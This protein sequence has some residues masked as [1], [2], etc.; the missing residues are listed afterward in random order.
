MSLSLQI[1]RH[2]KAEEASA[3]VRDHERALKGRG[4]KAAEQAGL[5]LAWLEEPP[6]LVLCSTAVRARETA[7]LARAAGGWEA[8]I[9][10]S[11]AI[12][13]AG[14]ETLRQE[15]GAV[16]AS[17]R[18]VLLVGHQPGLSL[19]I[20]ELTGGEPEFPTGTLARVD[21]ERERW[22][23]LAPGSG[24]LVWLLTPAVIAA[25]HPRSRAR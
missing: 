19:L 8:P 21:L 17:V 4:R 10:L 16:E 24:R 23:E 25:L 22:S 15:L 9:A 3:G 2:A 14:A 11:S 13:E 1:L 18:R 6:E 20:A 7:E 12:Y 5:T